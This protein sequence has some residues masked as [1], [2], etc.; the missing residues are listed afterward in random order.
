M[1]INIAGA[2]R[3]DTSIDLFSSRY[4]TLESETYSDIVFQVERNLISHNTEKGATYTC[5]EL[6]Q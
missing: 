2:S 6:G 3:R 5:Y 1:D 4:L